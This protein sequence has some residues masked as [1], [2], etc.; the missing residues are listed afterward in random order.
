MLVQASLILQSAL[1]LLMNKATWTKE[2]HP[3][4]MG[5]WSRLKDQAI[6]E[7]SSEI[8]SSSCSDIKYLIS[9]PEHRH[10][11]RFLFSAPKPDTSLHPAVPVPVA[12]KPASHWVFYIYTTLY[13]VHWTQAADWEETLHRSWDISTSFS[14]Q[15][16]LKIELCTSAALE[17]A[18]AFWA[19]SLLA[20]LLWLNAF[21]C[22]PAS[23]QPPHLSHEGTKA[24]GF[25]WRC[26]SC[27]KHYKRVDIYIYLQNR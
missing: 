22:F 25:E 27:Y 12:Q 24:S 21:G 16:R 19:V 6:R 9:S 3:S 13:C 18:P 8:G 23:I 4:L 15:I 5:E 20:F 10:E 11:D 1:H 26:W 2:M 7:A 14:V 17:S